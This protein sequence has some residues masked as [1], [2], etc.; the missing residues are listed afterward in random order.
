MYL[1]GYF[2]VRVIDTFALGF[3]TYKLNLLS[4]FDSTITH[5]NITWSW[6]LPDLM[7]SEGE[8]LEGFNF[9]G[10]GG[11]LL[12]ILGVYSFLKQRNIIKKLNINYGVWFSFII[13]LLLSLTNN[14]SIGKLEILSI[15]LS[16]YLYGPLSIVR[17]SGRL[18]WIISYFTLFL[19]IYFISKNYKRKS[20]LI[21]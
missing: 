18:F 13:I 7:L 5:K 1:V 20:F 15:P 6:F 14:I 12:I 9:L 3:G 8:E 4:I 11:L 16:D 21:F 17:S 2:E 19:S 10:L